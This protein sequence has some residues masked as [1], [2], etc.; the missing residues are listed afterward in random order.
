MWVEKRR[1]DSTQCMISDGVKSSFLDITKGF[2]AGV[3]TGACSLYNLINNIGLS[4][5]QTTLICM[6]LP[7]LLTRC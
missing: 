6:P 2:T 4:V 5:M 3:S 7:Q 1:S